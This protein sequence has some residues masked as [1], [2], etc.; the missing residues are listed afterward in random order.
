MTQTGSGFFPYARLKAAI[1]L[2]DICMDASHCAGMISSA[3][4]CSITSISEM[5]SVL[6]MMIS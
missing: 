5:N 3:P 1:A 4:S 6:M 2:L